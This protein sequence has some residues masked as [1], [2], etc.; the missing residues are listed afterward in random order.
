MDDAEPYLPATDM[1]R[2]IRD[3]ME[4]VELT[5]RE[6]V[7]I[8]SS[9]PV[10]LR[11]AEALTAALYEKFLALPRS[12]RFFLRED[13]SVDTERLERRKHS[14]AR[15]LRETAAA[16]VTSEFSY[17]LLERGTRPQ[18]P[19]ER[20]GRDDPCASDDRRDE[21]RAD[22]ARRHLRRRTRGVG[23]GRGERGVEQAR[24][25]PPE[26]AA[27]GLP[28][29]AASSLRTLRASRSSPRRH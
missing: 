28:A 23:S 16:A 24:A 5:E 27:A 14:L 8:R 26:R 3:M 21:S 18:P 13:G 6:V 4:F 29:A 22:G 2:F 9:A 20:A 7:A 10:V 12:A 19:R 1:P 17:Y 11:H 25:R 15:W